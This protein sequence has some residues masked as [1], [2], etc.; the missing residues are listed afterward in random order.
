[1][2]NGLIVAG[3]LLAAISL[4][5][6]QRAP[7]SSPPDSSVVALW[8]FDEGTGTVL[9]DASL[10]H[11]DGAIRN[12]SWVP[13]KFGYG[14]HF[15]GRTSYV[16]LPNRSSLMPATEFTLEAWFSLDTLQFDYMP[17]PDH[18]HAVIFGNLGPYPSGGG[19][20]LDIMG[21]SGLRMD[22][23]TGSSISNFSQFTPISS[24]RR[25]YHVAA[26]YR[27][28]FGAGDTA[29]VLN[30]KMYLNG[31]L[32]DSS[33]FPQPVEY[34]DCDS[35]YIGTN[36]D[37]RAVGGPGV[38]EF[39]GIIDE[40]RISKV[41]LGPGEFDTLPPVHMAWYNY[42]GNPVIAA[43]GEFSR[44]A[45]EQS[46]Y[47]DSAANKLRM[48][49]TGVNPS[50]DS[51]YCFYQATST[52][53]KTWTIAAGG[54]VLRPGDAGTFDQQIRN[55]AVIYDG[56][57]FKMYYMGLGDVEWS[58]GMASSPDG[59][60]WTKYAGNPI[61]TKGG[62]WDSRDFGY[63]SAYYDGGTYLLY[64]SAND[65]SS[66]SIGL[67]KS[68]DGYHWMKYSGNP[69][70]AGTPFAWDAKNVHQPSVLHKDGV[71]YMLYDGDNTGV[72]CSTDI[73]MAVS[74]D[75][76]HWQK[77]GDSPVLRR[78]GSIDWDGQSLGGPS[79]LLWKGGFHAWYSAEDIYGNWQIGYASSVVPG[80][81][82]PQAVQ[83]VEA[84]TV[85]D[86]SRRMIVLEFGAGGGA[87]D[88]IDSAYG[89]TELPPIPPSGNIDVR[90]LISGTQGSLRD[91]RDTLGGSHLEDVYT[92]RIQPGPGSY[93]MTLQ[94]DPA[95]LPAGTF[96]LRDAL[97]H[98]SGYMV[99]MKAAASFT[100]TESTPMPFEVVYTNTPSSTLR[101][102]GQWNMISLPLTVPDR[103]VSVL[104][105]TAVSQA[106]K[107]H[108]LYVPADT[109]EYG[110]GYWLKFDRDQDVNISGGTRSMDTVSVFER[111]NMIGSVSAPVNVS[112]IVE[113]PPGTVISHYYYY[114]DGYHVATSIDPLQSY[115][116]QTGG[117]G[118]LVLS[119]G[120]LK[121]IPKAASGD[122]LK[123]LNTLEIRDAARGS[124]TLYFGACE[125][126]AGNPALYALPPVPPEGAFDARFSTGSQ[127]AL[128]PCGADREAGYDIDVRS[129][130]Y[131]LNISWNVTDAKRARYSLVDPST[132]KEIA[133]P[134]AGT[135]ELLVRNSQVRMLRLKIVPF[136][137]ANTLPERYELSQ[138][139]P[140]PF[141][142]TTRI[143]YA[144]PH[145]DLVTLK[146]YN[147][148]GQEVKTLVNE[149]RPAG[150]YEVSWDAAECPSGVYWYRMT[151]GEFSAT[152]QMILIR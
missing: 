87:T 148:L 108:A 45:F 132:G 147:V 14:L 145:E 131:P 96:L 5:Y 73:G 57:E 113:I 121:Q 143:P 9:H 127:I 30:V 89:E 142:P 107:Y 33:V 55:P 49:F 136:S 152:H 72:C 151:S 27:K 83:F 98:G 3:L 15:D 51:R 2:K 68:S 115:W 133:P 32:T 60:T 135:G 39:P 67:A 129:S 130:S 6:P 110:Q 119:S 1:M 53:G 118:K 28:V 103:R 114:N 149:R 116:V 44:W 74:L 101:V 86:S 50:Y 54:P 144:L 35:F 90:W 80:S 42:Q 138:N 126:G 66:S 122:A 59:T 120:G 70:V 40:I 146:V 128:V 100:V 64:Y 47:Y 95:K 106:F 82:A 16:A 88:G 20:Q 94:W 23:R 139:Y 140:N 46:V 58:I 81:E 52:D 37:G 76:I 65:G 111:W 8:H 104:F 10:Y 77:T 43:S 105:P 19:Y 62:S 92:G 69:V 13:G 91:I 117:D 31:V 56:T 4:G 38:R 36:R 48:W 134:L 124:Q 109:L 7:L 18:G 84:V 93:P 11:N 75:A 12:A 150:R 78:G 41:A 99:N 34:A 17:P 21:D 25:F 123:Q 26:V 22:Y 79:L 71:W 29:G 141:N 85:G 137:L 61:L 112:D 97:T 125:S 24:A 102:L 63:P